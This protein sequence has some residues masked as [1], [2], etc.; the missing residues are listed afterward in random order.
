M[1]TIVE[2]L[3]KKYKIPQKYIDTANMI[4]KGKKGGK[5]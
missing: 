4:D 1:D 2:V 5:R 3:T